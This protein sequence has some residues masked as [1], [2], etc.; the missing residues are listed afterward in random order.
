MKAL[1]IRQ[2]WASLVVH[3]CKRIET[4]SW[5]TLYRG[6]LAIHAAGRRS[7]AERDRC[8]EQPFA[9]ALAAAGIAGPGALPAG[10]V[11]GIVT[12][13]DCVPVSDIAD[14]LDAPER[15]LGDYGAGHYAWLLGDPIAL[16]VP[17]PCAGQLGLFHLPAALALRLP[18][19]G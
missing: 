5:Q 10:A 6:P 3:G 17:L 19:N 16:A 1:S 11:V 12:L 2:P 18:A 14:Q 15:C 4:R 8:R 7:R 13:C 9:R